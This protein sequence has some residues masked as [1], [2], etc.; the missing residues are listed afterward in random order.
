LALTRAPRGSEDWHTGTNATALAHASLG[1]PG[2][3]GE[4]WRRA[5]AAAP[6]EARPGAELFASLWSVLPGALGLE[7]FSPEPEEAVSRME[8]IAAD[9][10][11][12][13]LHRAR[14]AWAM[15]RRA[16]ENA[17]PEADVV[18]ESYR[19]TANSLARTTEFDR[20][21]TGHL[22]ALAAA[23]GSRWRDAIAQSRPL[24]VY[25]SVG[26]LQRPF[27][28]AALYLDR[29]DWFAELAR[30]ETNSALADSALATWIWHLNT[31][32]EGTPRREV[33][34]GEID[35]VLGTHARVR[36][37]RLAAEFAGAGNPRDPER[38]RAIACRES[39]E[40]LR[41]WEGVAE[42]SL[43]PVIDEVSAIR[44]RL[45]C[46]ISRP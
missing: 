23:R 35:A 19:R 38:W 44:M 24:I 6:P 3:A 8:A 28:R 4:D 1:R 45:G 11:A 41:R 5:A 22:D 31:D 33:Q 17:G 39:G 26:N 40:V 14:A 29:G 46:R 21:L 27:G 37:A 2:R 34:A 36:I 16:A 9:T 13:R 12:D 30:R 32:L 15:A 20:Q 10:G 18:F 43:D 7:G 42:P 25:D